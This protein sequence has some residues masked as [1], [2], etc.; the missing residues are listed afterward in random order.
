VPIGEGSD[1][2]GSNLSGG[3]GGGVDSGWA[4]QACVSTDGCGWDSMEVRG[5]LKDDRNRFILAFGT[6]CTGWCSGL[7]VYMSIL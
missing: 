2:V 6:D 4:R 7:L 5:I 1:G 3:C